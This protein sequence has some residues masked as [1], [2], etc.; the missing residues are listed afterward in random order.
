[1]GRPLLLWPQPHSSN[2]LPL[3]PGHGQPCPFC[4]A[5]GPV[6]TRLCSLTHLPLSRCGLRGRGPRVFGADTC[7]A[8]CAESGQAG[9][10]V[11]QEA[12]AAWTRSRHREWLST[13]IKRWQSFLCQRSTGPLSNV[14]PCSLCCPLPI[15]PPWEGIPPARV[16]CASLAETLCLSVCLPSRPRLP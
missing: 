16:R 8:G 3:V 15:T 5:W 2:L 1:M 7:T 6:C 13:T 10:D 4:P 11:G 14:Y 12:A 9:R